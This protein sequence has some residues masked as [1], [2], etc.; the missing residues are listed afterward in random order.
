MSF[1]L[2]GLVAAPY[3]PF[4][5]DGELNVAVIPAYAEHLLRTGVGGVFLCGSTG[6]GL[7]LSTE[8]R[9]AVVEAWVRTV[10]GRF[11]V[12]VHVGHNSL[13]EARALAAHAERAGADAIAA[14]PPS[15]YKPPTV[16][17]LADF[18]A[19]VAESA[20]RLPF[21]YYHIPSMTG[22]TL[23][24]PAILREGAKRASNFRGV[25]FSHS[26]LMELQECLALHEFDVVFGYDEMLLAG[27]ALG[28]K[29]AVGSTYNFA[30]PLYRRVIEAFTSGDLET[31]RRE[32][33]KSV[34]LVRTLYDFGLMRAGKAA[35]SL[36]AIDCGPVRPPLA[37]L[38]TEEFAALRERLG[39]YRS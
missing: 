23:P 14:V 1:R 33:L 34:R 7:S 3:T 39:D 36:A 27:L 18:C 30:A 24:V 20:P 4:G 21:Y 29:G 13:P 35:M 31:A 37:P 12:V 25:K 15:Y 2:T 26:D 11:P 5:A 32:Q 22:V 6:E 17:A 9:Q 19:R 38:S 28:C 10:K 8:E 16:A